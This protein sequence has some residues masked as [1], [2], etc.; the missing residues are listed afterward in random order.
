MSG[1]VARACNLNYLEGRDWGKKFTRP[2]ISTNGWVWW[3][4]PITPATWEV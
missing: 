1:A 2:P 3:S 4:T